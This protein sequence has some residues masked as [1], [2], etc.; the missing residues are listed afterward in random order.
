MMADAVLAPPGAAVKA[1]E[2]LLERADVSY[3]QAHY[4]TRGCYAARIDRG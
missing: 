1:I 3:I 4:A 2:A